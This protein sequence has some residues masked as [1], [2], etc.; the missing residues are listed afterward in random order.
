[1]RKGRFENRKGGEGSGLVKGGEVTT[2]WAMQTMTTGRGEGQG[3][4]TEKMGAKRVRWGGEAT[5]GQGT[6]RL[7]CGQGQGD[8]IRRTRPG[9]RNKPQA[10]AKS[11]ARKGAKSRANKGAGATTRAKA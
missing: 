11:R 5:F 9:A 8:K 1:M 3:N 10:R 4:R 6:A 2:N 7:W